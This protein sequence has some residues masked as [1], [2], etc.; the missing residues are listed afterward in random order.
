[1]KKKSRYL[2]VLILFMHMCCKVI[3]TG[4]TNGSCNNDHIVSINEQEQEE[5]INEAELQCMM[6]QLDQPEIGS[7]RIK[8]ISKVKMRT[9]H[10]LFCFVLFNKN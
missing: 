10:F 3:D 2:F 1:M 5:R 6:D 8:L 7:K 9:D 4:W